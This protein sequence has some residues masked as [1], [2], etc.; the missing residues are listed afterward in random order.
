M[1]NIS[2]QQL[3][4]K[5]EEEL[6]EAKGITNEA[7]IREI[8]YSIKSLCEL[9][10]DERVQPTAPKNTFNSQQP[11]Y[12]AQ[13]TTIQQPKHLEEDDANGDSLFDF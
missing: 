8:V 6:Q 12:P 3:L 4:R 9:I 1:L 13:P 2:I 5:M 11:V 7:R 10:L